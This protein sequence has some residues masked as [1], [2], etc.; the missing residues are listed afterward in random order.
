MLNF[1]EK[2]NNIKTYKIENNLFDVTLT[3]EKNCCFRPK[4]D[5]PK[6]H[7][8]HMSQKKIYRY[9]HKNVQNNENDT[10][11]KNY[12]NIR[13]KCTWSESRLLSLPITLVLS[14]ML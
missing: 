1:D 13:K 3:G 12:I 6:Q 9:I 14:L 5:K 10:E 2:K 11:K 8:R 7:I 4:S